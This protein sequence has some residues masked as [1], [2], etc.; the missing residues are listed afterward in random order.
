MLLSGN[1][2]KTLLGNKTKERPKSPSEDIDWSELH[3]EINFDF[4]C[5]SLTTKISSKLIEILIERS[6]LIATSSDSKNI[7]MSHVLSAA[8]SLPE[9]SLNSQF[10]KMYGV[11][12]VPEKKQYFMDCIDVAFNNLS[13]EIV[14]ETQTSNWQTSPFI[15]ETI[16]DDKFV[17]LP[18]KLSTDQ[19]KLLIDEVSSSSSSFSKKFPITSKA[20]ITIQY[21]IEYFWVHHLKN[22]QKFT[23]NNIYINSNDIKLMMYIVGVP[24]LIKDFNIPFEV[25]AGPE[26]KCTT[27]LT[28]QDMKNYNLVTQLPPVIPYEDSRKRGKGGRFRRRRTQLTTLCTL[29]GDKIAEEFHQLVD[30]KDLHLPYQQFT[31]IARS[32][33]QKVSDV[34]EYFPR[35]QKGGWLV[36]QK[37]VESYLGDVIRD[38]HLYSVHSKRDHLTAD[39]IDLVCKLRGLL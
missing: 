31:S 27:Q 8:N 18:V 35:V 1:P 25:T 22:L 24:H 4:D 17:S 33:I 12:L 11:R 20:V 10:A 26:A 23:H 29:Q 9:F 32:T 13:H 21:F 14:T 38:A 19:F 39:D 28:E 6:I 5:S 36:L 16:G 2:Q 15:P 37:F 30:L 7:E 34:V 3:E